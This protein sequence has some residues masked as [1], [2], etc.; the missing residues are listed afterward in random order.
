MMRVGE[1]L[2][3]QCFLHPFR[4]HH[5]AVFPAGAAKRDGQITFAFADV[6]RDQIGQQAFQTQKFSGLRKRADVFADLAGLCR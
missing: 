3:I 5:G 1:P 4:H 6:V 2:L